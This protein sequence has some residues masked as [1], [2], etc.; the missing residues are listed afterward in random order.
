MLSF[1][2]RGKWTSNCS[3]LFQPI[4]LIPFLMKDL[5]LCWLYMSKLNIS[6]FSFCFQYECMPAWLNIHPEFISILVENK[7]FFS[8]MNSIS[9][10]L[11]TKNVTLNLMDLTRRHIFKLF[12]YWRLWISFPKLLWQLWGE[13]L[14]HRH[15]SLETKLRPNK[16]VVS[17]M[18][19]EKG[20]GK[21][22]MNHMGGKKYL[23]WD[24]CNRRRVM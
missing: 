15:S 14:H 12:F 6:L 19:W 20:N 21:G 9:V 5:K 24:L 18:K 8:L 17:F 7:P 22:S 1:F 11:L 10:S 4:F 3:H 16:M 13:S 2:A 23:F